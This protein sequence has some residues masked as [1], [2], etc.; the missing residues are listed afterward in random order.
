MLGSAHQVEKSNDQIDLYGGRPGCG[1]RIFIGRFGPQC[2]VAA[3]PGG[4]AQYGD[5]LRPGAERR[6]VRLRALCGAPLHAEH[7]WL[8]V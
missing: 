8:T 2:Y 4:D 7:G 1:S 6:R 5:Q 3:H